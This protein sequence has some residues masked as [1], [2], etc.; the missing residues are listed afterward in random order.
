MSIDDTITTDLIFNKDGSKLFL[1]GQQNNSIYEHFLSTP[2]NISTLSEAKAIKSIASEDTAP[3]GITFNKDGSKLFLIGGNGF[4]VGALF[5][6]EGLS[7]VQ[8]SESVTSEDAFPEGTVFNND[9]TKMFVLGSE[10]DSV[11]EY[12][13]STPYKLSTKS[14]VQ[15]TKSI[16][17][18][19]TS[20]SGIAFNNDGSKLFLVGRDGFFSGNPF[21]LSGLSAVKET[22]SI[23][24]EDTSPSGIAFNDDGFK[25]FVVGFDNNSVYEYSLT[26][27]FD[28]STLSSV[29]VTKSI[30]SEDTFP[31]GIAFNNDGT[32][33]FMIGTD[34]NSI[35][36]YDLSTAFDLSTLSTVQVTKSIATEDNNPS[37]I[38]FNADGTKIFMCGVQNKSIHEYDL[39][40]AFDLSTKSAVQV[41]KSVSSEDG[42][43]TGIIFNNDG[44]KLFVVGFDNDSIYE[45][46]LSTAFDIS[47]L[48]AVQETKSIASEDTF[49]SGI[50]FNKDG[51][52]IFVVGLQNDS[53]YEYSLGTVEAGINEYNLSTEFDI[54]TLS[55][56]QVSKSTEGDDDYPNGMAFNDDGSKLFICGNEDESIYEYHL[57][58]EFDI[59]TLSAVQVSR[60]TD[61][62]DS[63][64]RDIAFNGD[65]TKIFVV[66]SQN[67]SIYEYHLT[68]AFDLSTFSA[69]QVTR[70]I[71]SEDNFPS[72]IAFNGDGSKIFM[73][74]KEN[75]SV[76]EYNLLTAE[77]GL[78]EYDLTTPFDISTLSEVQT[79]KSLE[80]DDGSPTGLIFIND[81]TRLY[82]TGDENNSVY[83]YDLTTP[84]DISTLSAI[85]KTKSI[86]SDDSG[87]RAL[88]FNKDG[89][90][91]FLAGQQNDSVYE[92]GLTTPFDISTLSEVRSTLVIPAEDT[93]PAGITFI[94]DGT[95]LYVIGDAN[96]RLY[97]YDLTT[98][99]DISTSLIIEAPPAI[100][101]D[102][103]NLSPVQVTKSV[104]SEDANPRDIIFNDD[105]TKLF[106][107]G[108]QNDAIYE[109]NLSSA[110]NLLTKSAV[111]AIASVNSEETFPRGIAFNSDG[112]KVFI[113]GNNGF[114][115]TY[116]MNNLSAVQVTKSIG[117][118][119]LTLPLS[120]E[121]NGDGSKIYVTDRTDSKTYEY[122]LTTLFDLSTLSS[123]QSLKD[124]SSED[125]GPGGIAFNNDGSK[126]FMVGSTTC[127]IFEYNV[128]TPYDL[129]TLSV[130]QVTK[131]IVPEASDPTEIAF[132]DDGTK[133]FILDAGNDDI[134][135]YHLST[136][137]DLSTLSVRQVVKSVASEEID[138]RGMTFNGDGTKI[139]VCGHNS[140]NVNQYNLTTAYD[141]STKSAVQVSKSVN[142]EDTAPTGIAFNND[143]T[144]F[145]MVGFTNDS[146][147]EYNVDANEAG[148]NEYNLSAAFSISTLSAVQERK[149]VMLEDDSPADVTFNN[150]GTKMFM[151]GA[152]ND[153]IYEYN[154]TMPFDISTLS[155]VQQTKSIASDDNSPTDFVFNDVGDKLF[156]LGNQGNS[157]YEFDLSTA[158]DI[159]TLSAVQVTKSVVSEDPSP[160]GIT[161]NN[162]GTKIFMVGNTN[163]AMH[164]YDL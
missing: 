32:K 47:T 101:Y 110:Y 49:P 100:G 91:L 105:G 117:F 70:S 106:M 152:Q 136:A 108:A 31:R 92:Y 140:D 139:Y 4:I 94:N 22:K 115:V 154:L 58:T 128:V 16:A 129:S 82:V 107:L 7:T 28:I 143:G 23:S 15:F 146:I 102:L 134:S 104:A 61:E 42:Q 124:F 68:T 72:G 131:S 111:Q 12:D 160:R 37:G 114:Q 67:D 133:I 11:Y 6:L 33:M 14:T 93:P 116:D 21:D 41:T 35:H 90:K 20:P 112:T 120:V 59:S 122:N 118:G 85:Q 157:I 125:T 78:N 19:D 132:N 39:S 148:I 38:A 24:S 144:K 3:T 10:N 2:F 30:A 60:S 5:G 36:E 25:L 99:F 126:I 153:S 138:A 151:L 156:M 57:S 161:F 73:V 69:V 76:H 155:A 137:F 53:I 18:E 142:S 130:V 63:S 95:R 52:K 88:K 74:G 48:S 87:P 113:I 29:Q 54:S 127:S 150:D 51:K 55:T 98:P 43:P 77:A 123:I 34:S 45:Y 162:N 164:E 62:E 79:T 159:S 149:S 65:G 83:E 97:A 13:L 9:G 81:G 75:G 163:D 121:F 145:F 46:D 56:V 1:L 84:F 103:N 141:L 86:G 44:S 40:T 147:Y 8:V 66:G 17:S 96:D 135:E 27:P 158:F 119:E 71:V 80:S 50:A 26:T 109:Y 89:T 64:P